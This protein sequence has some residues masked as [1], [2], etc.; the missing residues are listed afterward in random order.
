MIFSMLIGSFVI[1][2]WPILRLLFQDG[3]QLLVYRI[4]SHRQRRAG[5]R[6]LCVQSKNKCVGLPTHVSYL[7]ARMYECENLHKICLKQTPKY[8]STLRGCPKSGTP[9]SAWIVVAFN[10]PVQRTRNVPDL[11]GAMDCVAVVQ[12]IMNVFVLWEAENIYIR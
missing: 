7:T 10:R 5:W 1:R 12:T 3:G 4:N 2:T 6:R 11:R 9:Y 8:N